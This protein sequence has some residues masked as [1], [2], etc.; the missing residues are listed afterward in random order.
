MSGSQS[1]DFT[2]HEAARDGK[3]L[4]VKGLVAENPKLVLKKDLDE[5]VPLHWAASFG[6]LEIVSVLLNP[7]KFQSDS[8]PKEQKIKPFTIDIDE[9]VDEAGW[10]PLHIASSVGNLDIVQLLLKNDPEPDVNLQSNNGSTP[11]HLATSKK[12]LGVVKE[13]IKH[14]ASVRI[15][16]KRSQY[17]LHRAASIGSLPL[18]ETFIKEGKSPINAKDSAGWTAV[19]HAL[20]EGHGDVA[21]LL[22]KSGADY[23]VEDDEGLTPLKVAVDDKVAQYFKAELKANGYEI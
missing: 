8:I 15:K 21:V 20:S 10:T 16:D 3:I 9:F 12:H 17:P 11:I 7:T 5:R 19:H 18:V 2:L 4:T 6:H 13:L 1:Q 22:V 14:G 23:N